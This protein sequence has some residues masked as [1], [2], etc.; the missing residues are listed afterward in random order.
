MT[1]NLQDEF[2]SSPAGSR[3]VVH[4]FVCGKALEVWQE[5]VAQETKI[6]YA[7]SV[8]GL[9]H[10][11]DT[12]LPTEAFRAAFAGCSAEESDNISYRYLEPISALQDMD[13]EFSA[14]VL[15]AYYAIYNAFC[16]YARGENNDDWI[17]VN[18]ALATD[19]ENARAMLKAALQQVIQF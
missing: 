3:K 5:F 10:E 4:R 18:Q 11:V 17:I 14:P 7:D 9:A 19:P 1:E 12:Q 16:K 15:M 2:L 13:L 8:V 6:T